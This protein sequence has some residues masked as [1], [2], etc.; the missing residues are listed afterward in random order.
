MNRRILLALSLGSAAVLV[1]S[2]A[3]FGCSSVRS[4]ETPSPNPTLVPFGEVIA[5]DVPARAGPG[6]EYDSVGEFS[7]GNVVKVVSNEGAWYKVQSGQFDS[8]VWVYA[9][10]IRPVTRL[11]FSSPTSSSLT[12]TLPRLPTPPL[13]ATILMRPP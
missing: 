9:Q 6:N 11:R 13:H 3:S 12:A 1:L 7:Q 8:D 2:I 4:D 5:D 10:F